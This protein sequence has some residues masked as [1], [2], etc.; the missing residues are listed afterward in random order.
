MA[1]EID[2]GSRIPAY[3][4]LILS[5]WAL[6]RGRTSVKIHLGFCGDDDLIIV[7]NLSPHPLEITS[8]G[9]VQANGDMFDWSD[10]PDAWPGL[11]KKLEARSECTL[12]LGELAPFSLYERKYKG[13][14]GCFV[15]I[16]GGRAFSDINRIR[17]IW[18]RI[19]AS[20]ER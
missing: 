3:A 20:V 13:R 9:V 4:G 17:R 2:W 19:R 6:W 18:W 8:L 7:A 16:A 1:E 15:R 5:L 11:P 12:R 14:S 10:G